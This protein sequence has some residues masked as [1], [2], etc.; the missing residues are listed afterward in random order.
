MFQ[1][2]IKKENLEKAIIALMKFK[3]K[4]HIEEGIV[5]GLPCYWIDLEEHDLRCDAVMALYG[6]AQRSEK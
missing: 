3:V 6:F 1:V 2:Q 4:Y 5:F